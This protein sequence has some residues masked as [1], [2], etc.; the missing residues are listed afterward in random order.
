MLVRRRYLVF[1]GKADLGRVGC[2]N[3]ALT[4]CQS[5]TETPFRYIVSKFSIL[6]CTMAF[7]RMQDYNA[8][9]VVILINDIVNKS[10]LASIFILSVRNVS[11]IFRA[12]SR[13]FQLNILNIF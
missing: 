9:A 10:Q 13:K 2:N 7:F 3:F 11:L 8:N 12:C 5:M 6:G 4:K 1:R